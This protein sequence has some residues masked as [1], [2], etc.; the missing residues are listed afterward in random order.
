M[1]LS[2]NPTLLHESKPDTTH[3]FLVD[4]DSTVSGGIPPSPMETPPSHETILFNW[5]VLT[6]PRLPSHI[7]FQIT[8]QV[9]GRDVPQTLIDEGTSISI[10]SSF[11]GKL[12][13]VLSLPWLR[14]IC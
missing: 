3:V 14:K 7:P 4:T 13:V 5:G 6:G 1:S 8:I 12:W 11:L 2:V 9:F 10:L